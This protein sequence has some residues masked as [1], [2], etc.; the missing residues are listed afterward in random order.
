MTV[1]IRL[2]RY[3][4]KGKPC[5]RVVIAYVKSPRDGKFIE[6]VGIYNP[7]L[8]KDNPKYLILKQERIEYWLSKGAQPT[9][10]V[11]KFIMG[12]NFNVSEKLKATFNKKVQNYKITPSKKEL[13][14]LNEQK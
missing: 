8:Q 2:A 14:K 9:D 4:C 5:Y 11:M 1:K 7:L 6:N 3:G 10:R 13:K 12:M